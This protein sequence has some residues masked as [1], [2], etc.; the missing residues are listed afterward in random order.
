[1]K[2]S[3]VVSFSLGLVL[4][5]S[6]CSQSNALTFSFDMTYD[7]ASIALDAGSTDPEGTSI[8]PGDSYS[9]G[10]HATSGNFWRVDAPFSQLFPMTFIVNP[11][12]ERTGDAAASFLR[13]GIEVLNIA[14]PAV[15][16]SEV[17]IG[18]QNWALPVGLEFD[19]VISTY[20]M[21]NAT[22]LGNSNPVTTTI[23]SQTD[24]FGSISDPQRPFFR[25]SSISFNAVP[26]PATL[27][28]ALVGLLGM[29]FARR[30]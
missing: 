2:A 26:E 20:E 16:Q 27:A 22:E 3:P 5:L 13:N 18:A 29:G 7:G 9:A 17:H 1:M 6:A 23:T 19:T 15:F 25:H 24:I 12:G 11:S 14:E 28:L 21:T 10:L 30:R 4:C 8:S